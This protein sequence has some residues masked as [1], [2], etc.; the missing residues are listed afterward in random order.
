MS[1][2]TLFDECLNLCSRLLEK[3]TI[4]ISSHEKLLNILSK[5]TNVRLPVSIEFHSPRLMQVCRFQFV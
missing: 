5:E 1:T 3:V 4:G 2:Q